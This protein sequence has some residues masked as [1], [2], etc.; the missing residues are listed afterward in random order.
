MKKINGTAILFS[1]LFMM[2]PFVLPAQE[3][4][5]VT[6]T[7]KNLRAISSDAC[8]Q[9]DFYAKIRIGAKLKT[10]PVREG[11]NITVNWQFI[12]TTNQDSVTIL[13]E[14]WDEDA[15]FCGD[16]DDEVCVSGNSKK[17]LQ[18]FSTREYKNQ[19]FSSDGTCT[20]SGTENAHI[21]YNITIQPV[22]TKTELLTQRNWKLVDVLTTTGTGLI[23]LRIIPSYGR[24]TTPICKKDDRY[25]F[26]TNT[27]YEVNEGATKCSSLDPHI[28]KTGTWS[29]Q[30][31]ETKIQLAILGSAMY[32]IF[33]LD[34]I[35]ENFLKL[36]STYTSDGTTYHR[37][38]TYTH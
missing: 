10:F 28:I 19:N 16:G 25:V 15:A 22:K 11:D 33:S 20:R 12:A 35:D 34:Q 37:M 6:V 3:R 24:L 18:K 14:I 17:V 38:M 27:R 29:F 7:I 21:S 2:T 9:M 26:R 36:S 13:I 23:N 4:A 32:E 30:I 8:N 1:I 5:T 31:N